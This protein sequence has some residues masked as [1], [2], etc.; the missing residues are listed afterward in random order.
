VLQHTHTLRNVVGG[1]FHASVHVQNGLA[2][3]TS[4]LQQVTSAGLAAAAAQGVPLVQRSESVR[5]PAAN[6]AVRQGATTTAALSH[7]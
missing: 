3:C 7:A 6:V 5:S 2:T 4:D 1:A